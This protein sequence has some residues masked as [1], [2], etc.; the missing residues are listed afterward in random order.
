M[1]IRKNEGKNSLWDNGKQ[2]A[3]EETIYIAS[4]GKP[5]GESTIT[6]SLIHI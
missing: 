2:Y 4:T 1:E 5:K 6:L 3:I